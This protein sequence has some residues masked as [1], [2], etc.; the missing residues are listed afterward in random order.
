MDFSAETPIVIAR[1]LVPICRDGTPLPPLDCEIPATG[2]TCMIGQD[3]R[4]LDAYLRGLCGAEVSAQGE[5]QLFDELAETIPSEQWPMLRMRLAY[6][7]RTAPLLSVLSAMENVILPALYHQRYDR[8]AAEQIAV[9]LLADLQCECDLSLLPAFLTPLQRTQ[10]A[11]ARMAILDPDALFLDEPYH[12][13]EL[14]ERTL[15]DH[16]LEQWGQQH[17][18]IIGT[19]SLRFVRAYADR[20]IFAGNNSLYHFASWQD[21]CQSDHGEVQNYLQQYHHNYDL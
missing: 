18:L 7:S 2:I 21:L 9:D 8:D 17:A 4:K 6:L 1:G 10:L 3:S 11:I 12:E 14:S 5:L 16:F 13:L 19:R 20:I 15:I